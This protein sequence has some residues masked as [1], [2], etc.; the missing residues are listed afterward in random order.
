MSDIQNA[1]MNRHLVDFKNYLKIA[2]NYALSG[3]RE[4][5][6]YYLIEADRARDD[7]YRVANGQFSD[8]FAE[9]A[10]QV[11]AARKELL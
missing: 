4:R 5:T 3:N 10:K 1:A 6:E 7:A 11:S 2:H 9:M 8:L